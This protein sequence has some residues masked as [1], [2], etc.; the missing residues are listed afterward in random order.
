MRGE[1]GMETQRI[2]VAKYSDPYYTT[3]MDTG[4]KGVSLVL[5]DV[6]GTNYVVSMPVDIAQRLLRGTGKRNA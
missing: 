3:D 6:D 4:E 1:E 2:N 5:T